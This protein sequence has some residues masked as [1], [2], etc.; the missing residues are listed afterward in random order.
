MLL[1]RPTSCGWRSGPRILRADTAAVAALDTGAVGAWGLALIKSRGS[2][3]RRISASGIVPG[4]IAATTHDRDVDPER[5]AD[6]AVKQWRDRAGA[7]G[8]GIENA[9]GARV[10]VRRDEVGHR[11]IKNR[12]GAVEHDP[13]QR[14]G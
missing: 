7:D 3:G 14:Q 10:L 1:Q 9:E 4:Q 6:K 8:A 11:T 13:D 12:R 2:C 5:V